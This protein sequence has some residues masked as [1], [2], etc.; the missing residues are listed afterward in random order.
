MNEY[1]DLTNIK[2]NLL[3]IEDIKDITEYTMDIQVEKT[4]YYILDNGIISHNSL[5][6]LTGTTSGMEPQFMLSYTR[7]KKINEGDNSAK[8]DFIDQ[9]G[10]KWQEFKVYAPK[11]KEW[12]RITGETNEAKSPWYGYCAD[13]INWT[14]K[15]KMQAAAQQHIGHS[16]SNTCNLPEDVSVEEVKKIYETAWETGCKGVTIYRKNSRSGVLVDNTSKKQDEIQVTTQ[17]NNATK[18]PKTL[19]AEVHHMKIKGRDYY[20]TVGLLDNK[21]YEIFV[22]ENRQIEFSE[23][24][25]YKIIIPKT[26][27]SGEIKKVKRGFYVLQVNDDKYKLNATTEDDSVDALTRMISTSLRHHVDV[28]FVVQQL[29]KIQ[30]FD[31]FPKALAKALKKYIIDGTAVSGENCPNCGGSNMVRQNGCVECM[32]CGMSRC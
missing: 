23:D 31:N 16:I 27:K 19:P 32:D 20:V 6:I 24:D 10:V 2:Y 29:E 18:R 12:M 17:N 25:Q 4:H 11:L 26:V 5:S 28:V 14:S 8:V 13:D 15:I 1:V 9:N 7:R 3:E 21:P 22:G 30:G